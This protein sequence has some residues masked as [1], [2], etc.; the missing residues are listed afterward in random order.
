MLSRAEKGGAS[1]VWGRYLRHVD[2]PDSVTSV[3]SLY[4]TRS[5]GR[6]SFLR[7]LRLASSF[8]EITTMSSRP[9]IR[10][11]RKQHG[12]RSVNVNMV[13]IVVD[14]TC[15]GRVVGGH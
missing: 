11:M 2:S 8:S 15:T 1:G 10:D 14:I 5:E 3:Y 9:W 6:A 12:P 4:C 7:P 13:G